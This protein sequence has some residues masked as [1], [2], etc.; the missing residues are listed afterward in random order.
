MDEN[1]YR[2]P[3]DDEEYEIVKELEAFF[4]DNETDLNT[5]AMSGESLV[6]LVFMVNPDAFGGSLENAER[7]LRETLEEL[8]QQ[9]EQDD[10]MKRVLSDFPTTKAH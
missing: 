8:E 2:F 7:W 5:V 1:D 6:N 10:S 9:R 4:K 3:T